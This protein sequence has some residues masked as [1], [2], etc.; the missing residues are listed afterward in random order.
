MEAHPLLVKGQ[1]AFAHIKE[2]IIAIQGNAGAKLGQ[3]YIIHHLH[4]SFCLK[5]VFAHTNNLLYTE[6]A[7]L[8]TQNR[9]FLYENTGSIQ[10][11]N[12]YRNNVFSPEHFSFYT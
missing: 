4:I 3:I 7:A 10:K 11:Q 9:D 12:S 1:P 5:A 2:V 8:C 6:T